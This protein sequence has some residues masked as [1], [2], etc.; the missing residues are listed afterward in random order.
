MVQSFDVIDL[1]YLIHIMI[2]S[3]D[4]IGLTTVNREFKYMNL[5]Y[6]IKIYTSYLQTYIFSFFN[7]FI[8]R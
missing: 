6:M 8:F 7:S 2:Q 1:F 3:H 5:T 4:Q